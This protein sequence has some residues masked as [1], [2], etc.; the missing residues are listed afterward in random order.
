MTGSRRE[1]IEELGRLR[2]CVHAVLEEALLRSRW[3]GGDA[4][5][6]G[7]W[8]PAVDVVETGEAF[9][10]SME[11]PGVGRDEVDLAAE[12]RRLVLTGRR[13]LPSDGSFAQMERS[14][15]PFRRA[16]ELP[17][18]IDADAVSAALERGV[19]TVTVPKHPSGGAVAIEGEGG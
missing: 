11:L 14:Y 1:F 5:P 10:L 2:E 17:E 19:L 6:P 3:A 4:A 16:F 12:G 7:G 15:G 8:A 18:A 9:V 13:P